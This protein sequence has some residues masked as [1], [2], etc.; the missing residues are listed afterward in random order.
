[1]RA[2]AGVYDKRYEE[3]GAESRLSQFD[4]AM[5]GKVFKYEQLKDGTERV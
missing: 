4:Y 1:M 2:C 3:K 5:H